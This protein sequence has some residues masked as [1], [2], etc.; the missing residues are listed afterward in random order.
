MIVSSSVCPLVWGP[1]NTGGAWLCQPVG[2]QPLRCYCLQVPSSPGHSGIPDYLTDAHW[3]GGISV[4]LERHENTDRRQM[5]LQVWHIMW[6][7][8]IP[9]LKL[10][11]TS[12]IDGN[13]FHTSLRIPPHTTPLPL[14][15][16][17]HTTTPHTTPNHHHHHN[18]VVFSTIFCRP[19]CRLTTV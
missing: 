7:L 4:P 14:P 8:S 6:C 11:L 12:R 19:T 18:I 13:L 10:D 5:V 3:S 17:H 2:D 9:P 15:P 16:H 1:P